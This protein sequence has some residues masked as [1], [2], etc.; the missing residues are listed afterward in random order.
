[1]L[2]REDNERLVKTGTGTPAGEL[3]RRYWQP[4][5]LS[6]EIAEADGAPI[7]VR[8]LGED[9]LAFRDTTG[10]VGLV[11]AFCPHRRAPLFFGRNEEC[12]LR[13]AYHGW[14]FDA[15]GTCIDLPSEPASSP[16]KAGIRITAY[17][18]VERGGIVWA[19]MGPPA[20]QP[21]EPDYEWMR[22]PETHRA[23]TK[24]HQ[25]CNYLQALEGGLDTAHVSFL[26]NNRIGDRKNLF[27]RDG[28]PKIEVFE[29]DYGYYYVSTRKLDADKNFVRVY[30]YTLPFQQMR[31]N[32]IETGLSSN[33]RVP[34]IDGHIWVPIDD[35]QTFVYNWAYG[36]DSDC[37]FDPALVEETEAFYGRGKGDFI[38]G[39]FRLK[40]NTSNDY[41]IDRQAQKT[42]SFTGIKGVNTQDVALQEGMGAFVDR[43][44]EH[45]GTSDRAIAVMRRMLLEATRIVEDGKSPRGTDPKT[46]RAVRPHEGVVPSGADWRDAFAEALTPKW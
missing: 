44:R 36:Y 22:V 11:D 7:R 4:A 27:V 33:R 9:L 38:P 34:R 10:R 3:F 28:A 16:M 32:V 12:G 18:T 21:P 25:A 37:A 42:T 15:D 45:L 43:T 8:L 30:Q 46:Y 24:S 35:D 23:V 20:E 13:C 17:P 39:T 2:R 29:T 14:K 31:P 5:L 1:M 19:Y 40:A 6:A 41:F 26:H